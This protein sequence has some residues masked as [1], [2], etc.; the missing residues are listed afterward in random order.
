MT[1]TTQRC[2]L[3]QLSAN[4]RHVG[5]QNLACVVAGPRTCLKY[6]SKPLLYLERLRRQANKNGSRPLKK[7]L[8]TVTNK[9]K[10]K[11]IKTLLTNQNI[12]EDVICYWAQKIMRNGNKLKPHL[13]FRGIVGLKT[14]FSQ[15]MIVQNSFWVSSNG[16]YSL[17]L[18][19]KFYF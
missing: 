6:L 7:I 5:G 18:F 4:E 13:Y 9:R 3:S 17:A 2:N 19:F 10:I 15:N 14:S 11:E 1:T 16:G 12:L 8:K